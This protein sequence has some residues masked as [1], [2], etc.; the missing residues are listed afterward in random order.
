MLN[1]AD[2]EFVQARWFHKGRRS[3]VSQIIVHSAEAPLAIGGERG[4][5]SYFKIEQRQA[6]AH[7]SVGPTG[8][9]Q[10]VKITDTA[11]AAVN[12][13]A[14]GVHIEH[15]GYAAFTVD[16]W[17][18]DLAKREL[19]L[20]AQLCA[21]LCQALDI[22]AER[23]EYANPDIAHGDPTVVKPGIGCHM[24]VPKH[25]SHSDPGANFPFESYVGRVAE[26]L[27]EG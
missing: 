20:S 24:W 19:E 8:I 27:A 1:L 22:P 17:S 4:V 6:S 26:I 5:A 16:Q 15:L 2:I 18:A 10:S 13:N 14:N 3:A 25:G 7:F 23:V 12:A 11:W 9:V 21:A